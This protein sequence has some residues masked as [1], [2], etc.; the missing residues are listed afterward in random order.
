MKKMLVG[1]WIFTGLLAVFMLMSSIPD[2]LVVPSAITVFEHLG[3]PDYLIPFLGIAKFLGVAALLIPGFPRVKEWVFAGFV[4]D[5]TGA[6]YSG[7]SVGDP[8]A[9]LS[10]FLIVYIL[11]FGAYIFHH[12]KLKSAS[13]S[14][15]TEESQLNERRAKLA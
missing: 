3:Y 8:A 13:L 6:M 1:Y 9:E 11:I 10:V 7:I 14:G 15:K 5:V 2:I 4:F 12:K